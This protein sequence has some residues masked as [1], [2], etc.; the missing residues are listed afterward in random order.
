MKKFLIFIL[1]LWL[2]P[3]CH[4]GILF[5]YDYEL[6]N[7]GGEWLIKNETAHTLNVSY[8]VSGAK[9]HRKNVIQPGASV[10]IFEAT[11]P[12]TYTPPTFSFFNQVDSISVSI[13]NGSEV[14]NNLLWIR[15]EISSDDYGIFN[16]SSWTC[17]K[18]EYNSPTWVFTIA[19]EDLNITRSAD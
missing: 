11:G 5:Q 14:T 15:S 6:V 2:L 8:P 9:F 4:L 12:N 7:L 10:C 13:S 19:N 1:L 3:S 17:T 18:N 16:E